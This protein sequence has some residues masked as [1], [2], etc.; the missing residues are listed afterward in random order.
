MVAV[1]G[2]CVFPASPQIPTL[3]A[4]N[5]FTLHKQP[6]LTAPWFHLKYAHII[7]ISLKNNHTTKW[8]L[9]KYKNHINY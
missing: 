9:E 5:P 6:V 4:E 7:L 3:S 8:Y 2:V 1:L